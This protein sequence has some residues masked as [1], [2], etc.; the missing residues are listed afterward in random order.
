MNQVGQSTQYSIPRSRKCCHTFPT[1][2]LPGWVELPATRTTC[3]TPCSFSLFNSVVD[4][5]IHWCLWI[6]DFRAHHIDCGNSFSTQEPILKWTFKGQGVKP[7]KL[8]HRH[9]RWSS[10][11][12]PLRGQEE[13]DMCILQEACDVHRSLAG[14]SCEKDYHGHRYW[15]ALVEGE[16]RDYYCESTY[17]IYALLWGNLLPFCFIRAPFCS[18]AHDAQLWLTLNF[19]TPWESASLHS[20]TAE[21]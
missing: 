10:S 16:N 17:P 11:Y 21:F 6:L 15:N 7:V 9:P 19:V 8:D 18:C 2:G 5:G 13:G 14:A 12:T 3:L 20:A 1:P 4:E